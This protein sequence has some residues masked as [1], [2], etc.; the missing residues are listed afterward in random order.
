MKVAIYGYG[1]LGKGVECAAYN[2]AD[3]ELVG[4]FTR[5]NPKE[6]VSVSGAPVYSAEDLPKF[7]DKIDVVILCGGS[8][9]DLPELTP[10]LARDLSVVESF[11][12]HANIPMH[13]ENTNA[14]A[15]SGGKVAV[16]SAGWDP[17]MF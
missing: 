13:I 6:I 16:I 2:A 5:R 10:S 8:A 9:K 3:T 11:D 14:A 1:N 12:T 15:L 4:I 7:K 17:G